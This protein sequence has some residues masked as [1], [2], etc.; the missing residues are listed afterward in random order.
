MCVDDA[1]EQITAN[2]AEVSIDCT[3]STPSEIPSLVFVVRNF[4]VCM[5]QE[6][7]GDLCGRSHESVF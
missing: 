7:D 4:R 5:V 2:Y 6:S 3:Q 1:M